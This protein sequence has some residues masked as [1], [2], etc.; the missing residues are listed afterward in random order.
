MATIALPNM[1]FTGISGFGTFTDAACPTGDPNDQRNAGLL[2][3]K[4]GPTVTNFASATA[5]LINVKGLTLTELG[6]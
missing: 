2:L 3:V 5:D 4:T 1:D 6:L